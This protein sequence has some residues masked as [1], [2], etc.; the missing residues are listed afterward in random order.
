[1]R[2]GFLR[3]PDIFPFLSV[4][5]GD[6]GDTGVGRGSPQK[7]GRRLTEGSRLME[8]DA[9]GDGVDAFNESVE[10]TA[11]PYDPNDAPEDHAAWNDGWAAAAADADGEGE[12][13]E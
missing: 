11:N 10:E 9:Y 3:L 2:E 12:D 5:F 8:P 6:D 13:D 1:M 4:L 7:L